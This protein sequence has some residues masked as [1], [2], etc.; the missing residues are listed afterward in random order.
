MGHARVH[1]G[2][3]ASL[4]KCGFLGI[5]FE[6]YARAGGVLHLPDQPAVVKVANAAPDAQVMG[7]LDALVTYAKSFHRRGPIV[8]G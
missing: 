3:R 7:D 2:C 4:C 6:P 5:T 8:S 1:Q